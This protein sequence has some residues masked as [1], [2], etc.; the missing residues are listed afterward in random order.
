MQK[1]TD[2]MT[3]KRYHPSDSKD[4]YR[5]IDKREVIDR[6]LSPCAD[7]GDRAQGG[8]SWTRN[9]QRRDIRIYRGGRIFHY[10]TRPVFLNPWPHQIQRGSITVRCGRYI[11]QPNRQQTYDA[12]TFL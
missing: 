8:H 3:W 9:I 10:I 6:N 4:D 2:H 5:V 7:C 12:R 11:L 1:G